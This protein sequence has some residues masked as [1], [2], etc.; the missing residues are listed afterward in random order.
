MFFYSYEDESDE[1]GIEDAKL[2]KIT[3]TFNNGNMLQ[4]IL[5]PDKRFFKFSDTSLS[6]II[7][8]PGNFS[9]DNDCYGKLFEN[10]EINL[11]YEASYLQNFN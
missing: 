4:M 8:L 7:E 1:A 2:H 9:L 11:N 3:P 10:V 5:P 6:Y